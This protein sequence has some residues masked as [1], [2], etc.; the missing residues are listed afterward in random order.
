MF[1]KLELTEQLQ[2]EPKDFGRGMRDR[3]VKRLKET[4]EGKTLGDLGVVV[5]VLHVHDTAKDRGKLEHVTGF[6][7]YQVHYDAIVFRPF[8]H[9]VVNGVVSTVS[10]TGFFCNVG[11]LN[12]FISKI[13]FPTEVQIHRQEENCWENADGSVRITQGSIVRM[14]ILNAAVIK[15]EIRIVGTIKGDFLGVIANDVRDAA[16]E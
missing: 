2:I 3:I 5:H 13:Q 11:P 10:R 4:V 12:A 1:F 9:Q 14:R 16:Y 8:P 6:A 15:S 7:C